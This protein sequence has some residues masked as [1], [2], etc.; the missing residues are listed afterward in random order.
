MSK[1]I[2]VTVGTPISPKKIGEKLKLVKTVN[3]NAPDENGNVEVD[4]N[5]YVLT[6]EDIENIARS[7]ANLLA[8][9]NSGVILEEKS[10]SGFFGAT[11]TNGETVYVGNIGDTIKFYEGEVYTVVFDG[12][13][14]ECE[15]ITF[16]SSGAEQIG[17]RNYP[18]IS[19]GGDWFEISYGANKEDPHGANVF[20]IKE[21]TTHTIGIYKAGAT[22][23]LTDEDRLELQS[24]IDEIEQQVKE[25]QDGGYLK[26][27]TCTQA[28]YDAMVAAGTIDSNTIYAIVG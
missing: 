20:T 14:Y 23:F 25:I 28:E 3:G 16:G 15:A 5:G 19:G 11:A 2:G 21:G 24:Q 22:R 13:S 27:V 9:G 26:G 8:E 4:A 10:Y 12:V 18:D 1:I 7:A 6:G 17:I